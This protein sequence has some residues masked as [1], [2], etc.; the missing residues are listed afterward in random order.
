MMS[1]GHLNELYRE[2]KD[3]GFL[4]IGVAIDHNQTVSEARETA[5]KHFEFPAVWDKGTWMAK[6]HGVTSIPH[7]V[8]LDKNNKPLWAGPPDMVTV[9][10]IKRVLEDMKAAE[11]K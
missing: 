10:G 11:A 2:T 1:V 7:V 9:A 8:I 6:Q 4:V 3:D 5:K